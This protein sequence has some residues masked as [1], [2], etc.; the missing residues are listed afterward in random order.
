MKV[1]TLAAAQVPQNK[2]TETQ[3][4]VQLKST[5]ATLEVN[6]TTQNQEESMQPNES[7]IP[8]QIN[9]QRRHCKYLDL[10]RMADGGTTGSYW[11]F[12]PSTTVGR[13]SSDTELTS[14][15]TGSKNCATTHTRGSTSRDAA[16]RSRWEAQVF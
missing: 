12:K 6:G 4:E 11:N 2:E 13:K 3:Q 9:Q 5:K 14:Q 15:E 7:Q 10:A 8:S 1:D 16:T